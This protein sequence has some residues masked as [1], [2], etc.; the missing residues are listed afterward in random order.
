MSQES[1]TRSKPNLWA[2]LGKPHGHVAGFAYSSAL[3]AV[4]GN[5]D[6]KG[7]DAWL[8]APRKY[9]PGTKMNFIG[10]KK[11]E[12]RAALLAWLRTQAA[13]PK[14]LPSGGEIAAEAA[15]LT[16]PAP[17]NAA[18]ESAAAPAEPAPAAH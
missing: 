7:M 17:V 12:D 8:A 18:A 14:G 3:K 10:I 5:W 16:P 4:P 1:E 2:A 6:F 11:P 15:E 9:A 13:S